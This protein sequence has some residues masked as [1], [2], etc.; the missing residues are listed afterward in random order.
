MYLEDVAIMTTAYGR[1]RYLRQSLR[2]WQKARGINATH[3]FV[4]ALGKSPVH[5]AQRTIIEGYRPMVSEIYYDRDPRREGKMHAAILDA[6]NHIFLDPEVRFLIFGEEDVV[7]SNDVLEYFSWAKDRFA[8]DP[9]VLLVNAHCVGGQGWDK[10]EPAPD[11]TRQ[12]EV[13]LR[14]YFN[15][16]CW[17]TWRHKWPILRDNWDDGKNITASAQGYDWRIQV[18]TMPKGSYLAVTPEASRSQCIGREGGVYSTEATWQF[19]VAGS[20]RE[21]RTPGLPYRLVG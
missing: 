15:A 12:R 2:S 8:T 18:S 17:G 9:R 7:V 6:A 20:F 10:H 5:A 14:S 4:V 13:S 21:H 16:W 19:A 11:T 3:S 1:P